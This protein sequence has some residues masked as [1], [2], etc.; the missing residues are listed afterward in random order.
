M[1]LGWTGRVMRMLQVVVTLV[2]VDLLILGGTILGLVVLG[3]FPALVAGGAVLLRDAGEGG[4]VRGFART[5]RA[6]FRRANLVGAPFLGAAALLA[7]D[8]A[9]L[10][11]VAGPLGAALL[12]LTIALSAGVLV[13][14]AVAVALLVRYDGGPATVLRHAVLIA[15]GSPGTALAVLVTAVALGAVW[16]ALPVALALVGASLPL[17]LALR[18]IDRRLLRIDQ[19]HPLRRPDPAPVLDS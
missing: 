3:L 8:A 17:L 13:T 9:V 4:T 14:A 19:D 1:S 11:R 15:A 10:P 5:Y 2:A 6:E 18:L 12:V 7:A 16:I